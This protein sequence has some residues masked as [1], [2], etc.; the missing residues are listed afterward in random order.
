MTA[1]WEK[2]VFSFSFLRGAKFDVFTLAL[3]EQMCYTISRISAAE[4]VR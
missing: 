1:G 3:K 2:Q 4:E